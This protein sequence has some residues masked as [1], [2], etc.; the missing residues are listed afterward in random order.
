[1]L[2][3]DPRILAVGFGISAIIVGR[4]KKRVV[5]RFIKDWK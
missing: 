2:W 1:L 4:V 3:I 5:M